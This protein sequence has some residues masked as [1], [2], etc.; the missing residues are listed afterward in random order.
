MQGCMTHMTALAS[1]PSQH[2]GK[3]TLI[4]LLTGLYQP[5]KGRILLDGPVLRR[6]TVVSDKELLVTGFI[7]NQLVVF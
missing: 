5:N 3:T 7:K 2:P 4:K 6:G 1:L